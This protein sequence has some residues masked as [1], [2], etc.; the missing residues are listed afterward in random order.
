MDW[1]PV[2]APVKLSAVFTVRFVPDA[3]TDDPAPLSAHWL[4]DK[5]PGTP[6]VNGPNHEVPAS[7]IRYSAL[8]FPMYISPQE[9][10]QSKGP[11][12]IWVNVIR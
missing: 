2:N 12:I 6:G 4:F 1:S 11:T 7:F 9:F 8:L 5:I 10:A 3:V